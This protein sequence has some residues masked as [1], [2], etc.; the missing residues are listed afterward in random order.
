MAEEHKIKLA[1]M[2]LMWGPIDSRE[3]A[4]GWLDDIIAAGYDGVA[5]FDSVLLELADESD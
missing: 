4:T 1:C 5:T 2:S 3:K